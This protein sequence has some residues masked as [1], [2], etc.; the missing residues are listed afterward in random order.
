MK[1]SKRLVLASDQ[2]QHRVR[3]RLAELM[4][5]NFGFSLFDN[6]VELKSAKHVILREQMRC[7]P[8]LCLLDTFSYQKEVQHFTE[9]GNFIN[10]RKFPCALYS[11]RKDDFYDPKQHQLESVLT[12]LIGLYRVKDIAIIIPQQEEK[13]TIERLITDINIKLKPDRVSIQ[14]LT[15]NE[16]TG[17]EF[18][19]VV[20]SLFSGKRQSHKYRK[21]LLETVLTRHKRVLVAFGN[22]VNRPIHDFFKD[23]NAS[24]DWRKDLDE[25]SE[26]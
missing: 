17:K 5:K 18:D 12:E 23:N 21:N 11:V 14:I 26:Q 6:L 16:I 3:T 19:A 13:E 7:H 9:A 8:K 25:E 15:P 24:I 4:T 2:N 20:L 1:C 10:L 22:H